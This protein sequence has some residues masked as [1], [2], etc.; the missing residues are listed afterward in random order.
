MG[1]SSTT[2]A[3]GPRLAHRP[4]AHCA[5]MLLAL[6][7]AGAAAPCR[8]PANPRDKPAE[9]AQPFG[10][11][12]LV[13]LERVSEIAVSPDG[14]S[15]AFTLRTTD[16]EANKGRTAVWLIATKKNASPMRLTDAE[17]NSNAAEWSADGRFIY[18]LSNKSGSTQVWRTAPGG[19]ARQI[20]NLPL[21]VGSFRVSPKGDRLLVSIETFLDCKTLECTKLRLDAAA[22]APSRGVLYD[23]IFVRHWDTWSDGRRSQLFSIK[24]DE[25]GVASAPPVNLSAGLDGDVPSKPFG[26]REDYAISPDGQ[27]VAFSI[28]A[29][30]TGEPWSTNFDIY[31]VGAGGGTPRNLTADNPAWDAQPAFSPDG[32][33]LA[34][35][36]MDRPGFEADR[37]H[38]VLLNWQSGAKR[39][40]TRNWDRSIGSFAWSRDGKT[41]FA[42]ADHL[43]QRPLWAIDAATG[44]ASAITGDGHVEGFSVGPKKVFYTRATLASPADLYAVSFDGGKPLKLTHLNQAELATR[45]LGEYQQFTFAG[46][47]GDNVFGFV[48]KPAAFKRDQKY[49]VALLVHGGP[50]GSLSNEWHWRWNAQSFAGAGYGV[51]MVDF[52]GSTGYGQ[53]FTDSISGD[54]GGKPLED[55]KLGL[56]AAI[57]QYPWLDGDDACALGG[58]YGGFMIN[59]IAGRWPDR[60]KCLVTHDGVFDNRTMYYSTEELWFPEWENGGPEYANPAG[61]A[62]SNPVDYVAKWKTPT[63]VVHGQFDY[64]VPYEQGIAVFTAL[65]RLGVPSELLYFPDENHWVLKPANS[66][67]WYDTV[68]A[69]MNRWTRRQRP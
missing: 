48:V 5:A 8:A 58:S 38:L 22:H 26:A 50:Q 61:Y 36:A 21:D 32:A 18:F 24:L 39:P 9:P 34:Y 12:D 30:P 19:E 54:W 63:L 17:A 16:M 60:F 68:L 42:T 2:R 7:A 35:L 51:V 59:W 13:R 25:A 64:R 6:L 27:Q 29:V 11:R 53:A 1:R 66:I 40:L 4:G 55:L 33:T 31:A 14:K 23:K 20:T 47:G 62:K 49:P 28:R 45:S 52:H 43:G 67:L 46:A 15:V 10:V 56:A 69:W 44:R 37:F 65:Q 41:L 57:K 3:H